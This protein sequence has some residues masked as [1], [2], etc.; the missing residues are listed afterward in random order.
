MIGWSDEDIRKLSSV[1]EQIASFTASNVPNNE[2]LYIEALKYLL[3]RGILSISAEDV[4]YDNTTS[5]LSAE[6]VQ[7][8]I[9]E[10]DQVLDI[11][12]ANEKVI[13]YYEVVTGAS[14]GNQVNVPTGGTILLDK[15]G[16]SEDAILSTVD[17]N[18]NPTFESPRD[19][20]GNV[21]TTSMAVDGTYNFSSTPVDANVAILYV[22]KIT[23][24]DYANVDINFIISE[25]ELEPD[26]ERIKQLYE[27]N[28]NTNAFTD[29]EKALVAILTTAGTGTLFLADDGTYKP[30][31]GGTPPITF[32]GTTGVAGAGDGLVP[33]DGIA[34]TGTRL[35]AD[36][37][38][39]VSIGGA[40]SL[41]SSFASGSSKHVSTT[42][43]TYESLA[44]IIFP[45]SNKVGSIATIDVNAW[46]SSTGGI[47]L[48]TGSVRIVDLNSGLTICEKTG[49]L[50]GL[51]SN[52]ESM[53]AISNIPAA[54]SVFEIQGRKTGGTQLLIASLELTYG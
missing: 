52:I 36:D 25:D 2:E 7:A 6:Q 28:A 34:G 49:I 51:E 10:L 35:L 9:D 47:P 15:F 26:A 18:N 40:K 1:I 45:G 44:H 4:A 30:A 12:K 3:N 41:I 14:S 20:G 32:A 54:A 17:G 27:S 5:G 33:D 38:S 13:T 42:S 48:K 23:Q 29:V 11:L 37:G 16:S 39:W 19:A 53:G 46:L 31:G 21:V 22:F 8:A 24:L 43:N 50:A